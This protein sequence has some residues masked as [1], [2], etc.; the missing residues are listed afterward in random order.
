[1]KLDDNTRVFGAFE[2]DRA[3]AAT[4]GFDL[5]SPPAWFDDALCAQVDLEM[6]F[7]EKGESQA[8]AKQVC[9][10][11]PV[12]AKCLAYALENRV[13]EGIWGGTSGRERRKM[14]REAS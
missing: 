6:F 4:K 2:R 14:L 7:P 12:T 5:P 8:A 10:L 13:C 9:A 11:C 3:H 1:V